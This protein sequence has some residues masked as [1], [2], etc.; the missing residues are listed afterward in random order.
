MRGPLDRAARIAE[1]LATKTKLPHLILT[2]LIALLCYYLINGSSTLRSGSAILVWATLNWLMDSIPDYAVGLTAAATLVVTGTVPTAV[3]FS[4]FSNSAW[5]LLVGAG[6]M[7]VAVTRSGLLYRASLHML[8]RLPATFIGQSLA[9][10][11]TGILFTPLLPSANSRV[12]VAGPL[13]QELSEGMRYP[14]RGNGAAG[15]ALSTFLGFGVMY[16]LF[17]NG[18]NT[19]L[20]AWS[21]LPVPVRAEISWM[22]WF[23]AALPMGALIFVGCYAAIL[24][25]Y[26]PEQT[27]GISAKV[28]QDQLQVL[29]PL[30]RMEVVTA[31]SLGLVLLGFMTQG[32]H[33]LDPAWLALFGFLLLL[34]MGVVDRNG[35]KSMD[36]G[37]LLLFGTLV[38]VS[39]ITK[40]LGL[41]TLASAWLGPMIQPLGASPYLLMGFIA[42]LTLIIRLVLP[43]QPTVFI[44]VVALSDIVASMGYN[45]FLVVLVVLALSNTWIVPQQNSIYLGLYSATEGRSFSHRQARPLALVHAALGILAVLITVPFWRFLGLISS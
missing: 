25:L 34:T 19:G 6:G 28:V 40:V 39:E 23:V 42:M 38:S 15:L 32:L 13:A 35:L 41:S 2:C 29:G 16:F 27:R 30:S 36:W 18:A 3:A 17:L 1:D 24:R 37:F 10:A 45:P 20:L 14:A 9:M 4:G 44:L 11:I 7:G 43:L 33:R 26:P 12:A 22:F 31:F 21:L 8:R 5:L